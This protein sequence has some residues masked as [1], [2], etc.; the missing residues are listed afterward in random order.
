MR[1]Q[2]GERQL[3]MVAHGARI[4]HKNVVK[5]I[6]KDVRKKVAHM[7]ACNLCLHGS[8]VHCC[9]LQVLILPLAVQLMP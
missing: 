4:R 9:K 6:R 3:I 1:E 5:V 2:R 7:A 8:A